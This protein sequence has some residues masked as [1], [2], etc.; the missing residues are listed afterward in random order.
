MLDLY[1]DVAYLAA[2]VKMYS[3]W[4][5][6]FAVTSDSGQN[7]PSGAGVSQA[8]TDELEE[9]REAEAATKTNEPRPSPQP[10]PTTN[11]TARR[12]GGRQSRPRGTRSAMWTGNQGRNRNQ[13]DQSGQGEKYL[14]PKE[15][16]TLVIPD[17]EKRTLSWLYTKYLFMARA[18]G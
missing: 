16:V 18:E 17:K 8:P 4:C 12:G 9:G 11:Q 10:I 5:C 2:V 1:R 3:S 13:S 14:P 6:V 7:E 15:P